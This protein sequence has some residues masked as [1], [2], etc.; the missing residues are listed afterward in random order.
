MDFSIKTTETYATR[1]GNYPDRRFAAHGL[2]K[3][4]FAEWVEGREATY[5][6]VEAGCGADFIRWLSSNWAD[7]GEMVD[8]YRAEILS[9]K[10]AIAIYDKP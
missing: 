10:P 3:L 2:I 9:P 8:F 5:F 6:T 1:F 4:G 7:L